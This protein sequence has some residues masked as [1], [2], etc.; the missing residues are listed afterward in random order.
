MPDPKTYWAVIDDVPTECT[1][2]DTIHN[3]AIYLVHPLGEPDNC[4]VSLH[5][6]WVHGTKK[7]CVEHALAI[8]NRQWKD[9]EDDIRKRRALQDS[10]L[11]TIR[12]LEADLEECDAEG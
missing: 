6:D 12:D 11:D 1:L 9:G 8:L 10:L 3:G 5:R 2:L 7:A 4:A